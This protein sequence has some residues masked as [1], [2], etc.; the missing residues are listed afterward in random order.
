MIYH[1][2]PTL[3][4]GYLTNLN[5]EKKLPVESLPSRSA[6]KQYTVEHLNS[7]F[8]RNYNSYQMNEFIQHLFTKSD[9]F[10][11]SPFF[12]KLLFY[13]N[14]KNYIS[15]N[16]TADS[17]LSNIVPRNH[18]FITQL[19]N[20]F[21]KYNKS[22]PFYS[23]FRQVLSSRYSLDCSSTVPRQAWLAAI[24]GFFK[25]LLDEIDVSKDTNFNFL[26]TINSDFHKQI[27]DSN[28]GSLCLIERT[29][30]NVSIK[31][32]SNWLLA[33]P[34]FLPDET[35][36]EESLATVKDID[37]EKLSILHKGIQ[38]AFYTEANYIHS[39][40]I[41]QVEDVP[42]FSNFSPNFLSALDLNL[43]P[44][45]PFS[46]SSLRPRNVA[47]N[48]RVRF[49][50]SRP[51]KE[52]LA[53]FS[54]KESPDNVAIDIS[55]GK[56]SDIGLVTPTAFLET[57]HKTSQSRNAHQVFH[58][59]DWSTS[60][61]KGTPIFKTVTTNF[62][63][64]RKGI[65]Y[66]V[67]YS[68][69]FLD[70]DKTLK[71]CYFLC[72][73]LLETKHKKFHLLLEQYS[74]ASKAFLNFLHLYSYEDA[75]YF[76]DYVLYHKKIKEEMLSFNPWVSEEHLAQWTNYS[77]VFNVILQNKDSVWTNSLSL[78]AIKK[79]FD[80]TYTSL[81]STKKVGDQA[82]EKKLTKILTKISNV[83]LPLSQEI[84]RLKSKNDLALQFHKKMLN[85]F[86]ITRAAKKIAASSALESPNCS[87]SS[88][89][90]K[91]LKLTTL[92]N[93]L[94][95]QRDD[96]ILN[97]IG[98]TNS[99]KDESLYNMLQNEIELLEIVYIDKTK[100]ND[101]LAGESKEISITCTDKQNESKLIEAHLS[102]LK[103][104]SVL[105]QFSKPVKININGVSSRKKPKAGGPYVVRV[106]RGNL[107]IKCKD[108]TSLVGLDPNNASYGCFIHPH[109]GRTSNQFEFSRACLGEAS[110]LIYSAF[111]KNCLKTILFSAMI[112]V[113]SANSSDT[114]GKNYK[115]FIN[116]ECLDFTKYQ[117]PIDLPQEDENLITE[118]EVGDFFATFSEDILPPEVEEEQINE[119]NIETL[120]TVTEW[121]PVDPSNSSPYNS[122]RRYTPHDLE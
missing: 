116:Y 40:K 46:Y 76:K 42:I 3:V 86:L 101:G 51:T 100:S 19:D 118:E 95:Q 115:H 58:I 75:L 35:F 98:S 112:W 108:K 99:P 37:K 18:H 14:S 91:L 111:E 97:S 4:R 38:A 41:G 113:K 72:F 117:T 90:S 54:A 96:F 24:L 85:V 89:Y 21:L 20:K 105:F 68:A 36:S 39:N 31:E 45:L 8:S 79:P 48:S 78:N 120:P 26:E 61:A 60:R 64:K 66:P 16:M 84:S 80:S 53:C 34:E 11:P 107:Y 56:A 106:Q 22:T 121:V 71:S 81:I 23:R 47:T 63:S 69:Q 88:S 104:S 122:Y 74:A 119:E 1:L 92:Q 15:H 43:I 77:S 114:W 59:P 44:K 83:S 5:N 6:G 9:G 10:E 87:L 30:N 94:K 102:G 7:L 55:S 70:K 49:K 93:D 2:C 13:K 73:I 62:V 50:G 82:V 33:S 12:S 32:F 25:I 110:P 28:K 57:L 67:L 27:L 17:C 52:L 29:D 65:F 109:T 103:I